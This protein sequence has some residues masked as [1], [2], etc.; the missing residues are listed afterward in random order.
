MGEQ[1]LLDNSL[2]EKAQAESAKE[3]LIKQLVDTLGLPPWKAAIAAENASD[4]ES[5]LAFLDESPQDEA[6]IFMEE[7]NGP[8]QDERQ[9][10]E[11]CGVGLEQAQFALEATA[12]NLELACSFLLNQ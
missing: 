2:L 1:D 10:M 12:G 9:V 4:I 3:S 5:A 6:P 7:A 8:T 11:V